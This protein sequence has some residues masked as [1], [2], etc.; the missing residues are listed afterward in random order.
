MD[1][2]S[3]GHGARR[4]PAAAADERH[5]RRGV[6]DAPDAGDVVIRARCTMAA[7]S[8]D[9]SEIVLAEPHRELHV[10]SHPRHRIY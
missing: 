1:G 8:M 9:R 2:A 3:L 4:R 7:W 6:E 10:R 5:L